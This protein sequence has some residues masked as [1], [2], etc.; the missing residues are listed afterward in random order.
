MVEYKTFKG[1]FI[2]H[3][4]CSPGAVS[5]GYHNINLH[6]GCPYEC[7]YCILQVYLDSKSPIFYTNL[8]DLRE[9]LEAYALQHTHIR[10]GSGE[11]SDSLAL[12][13]ATNYSSKILAIA[14]QFPQ[15]IF[16]FKTKST[17]IKNLLNYPDVLNN[18][19]ISWSLNP[20]AIIETEEAHTPALKERLQAMAAIQDR[21]YKIGV[22]MDPLI[23]T[24]DWP[25]LYQHLVKLLSAAIKPD[26]IAWWSLGSLRFPPQLRQEIF[27]NKDSALF[28]GELVKGFDGKFR[29][30]KPQRL[31]LF[32][33]LIKTIEQQFSKKIPLYLCMEDE[34][35]WS[36]LLPH[37]KPEQ[38]HINEYL[39]RAARR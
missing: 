9:E 16:E 31:E 23:L 6:T 18:V 34:E 14:A 33:F 38:S 24:P 13:E 15:I 27:K 2:K 39:Y 7:T 11:L 1:S 20:K 26:K 25:S 22:H 4:P 29:Y 21:G 30:F 3:C 8:S 36:L 35:C 12:D 17:A 10:I 19:V 28:H 5:C 37:I 32:A